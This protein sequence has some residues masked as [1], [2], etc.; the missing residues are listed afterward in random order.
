MLTDEV[1]LKVN[2]VVIVSDQL[3][4][5]FC[6]PQSRHGN[7]MDRKH[8]EGNFTYPSESTLISTRCLSKATSNPKNLMREETEQRPHNLSDSIQITHNVRPLP[9]VPYKIH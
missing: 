8:I 2:D 6:K 1:L 9:P 3:I 7:K 4:P 5:Q